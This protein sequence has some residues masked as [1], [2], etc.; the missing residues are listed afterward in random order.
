VNQDEFEKPFKKAATK[1]I[2]IFLKDDLAT[3]KHKTK[4]LY[5]SFASFETKKA[6]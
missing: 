6:L 3:K 2:F 5:T 1:K 4:N